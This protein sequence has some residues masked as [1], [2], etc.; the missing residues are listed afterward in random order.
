MICE[1][2]FYMTNIGVFTHL[3]FPI[4]LIG[5]VFFLKE[6]QGLIICHHKLL[7]CNKYFP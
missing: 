7:N 1:D 3:P 5:V 2:I 6:E 4:V